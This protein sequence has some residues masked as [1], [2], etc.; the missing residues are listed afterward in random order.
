MC[1]KMQQDKSNVEVRDDKVNSDTNV[2]EVWYWFIASLANRSVAIGSL[3]VSSL[4]TADQNLLTAADVGVTRCQDCKAKMHQIRFLLKLRVQRSPGSL[5]VFKGPLIRG[6]KG[7]MREE[8]TGSRKKERVDPQLGSLVLG[9]E[10]GKKG[11]WRGKE[12]S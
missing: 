6:Q 9:V 3:L 10:E 2:N 1:L 12:R 11:E 8:G 4:L 5:A 7:E